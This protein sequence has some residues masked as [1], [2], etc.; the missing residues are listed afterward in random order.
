MLPTLP[1]DVF[2]V[3]SS[4]S[5]EPTLVSLAHVAHDFTPMAGELLP[6]SQ[7]LQECAKE[8]YL[9]LLKWGR[10][11]DCDWDYYVCSNAAFGGH[12]EVLKW[13]RE[14]GCDWNSDMCS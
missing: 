10:E 7:F 9:E 8:G 11:N 4:F 6:K 12:L 13:A 1:K 2:R 5:D 3:I 14:N